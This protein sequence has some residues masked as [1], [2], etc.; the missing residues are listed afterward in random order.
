MS[1]RRASPSPL[2]TRSPSSRSSASV[3]VG[4]LGDLF[5]VV[6]EV[7]G[8]QGVAVIHAQPSR[9]F[10]SGSTLMSEPD[11]MDQ[12]PPPRLELLLPALE[13]LPADEIEE[14]VDLGLDLLHPAPHVED[15]LDARQ[16]HAEVPDE[17]QD[18]LE[19]LQVLVRIHPG[20][21]LA[22]RRFEE[23][24]PLVEAERLRMD[25]VHLRDAADMVI[26]RRGSALLLLFPPCQS[27][28]GPPSGPGPKP[29]RA[30]S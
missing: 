8:F 27:L 22:P 18:D 3:T 25:V 29:F 14:R 26:A 20:V 12:A 24:F 13:E 6:L 9:S 10:S 28:P 5:Q 4:S 11:P 16:V 19:P 15:D 17:V 30:P 2:R 23:A 21:P 7:A 1:R